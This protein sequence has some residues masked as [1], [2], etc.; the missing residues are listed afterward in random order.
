MN[1]WVVLLAVI[2]VSAAGCK[3]IEITPRNIV[4][5][6][7]AFK[8][9]QDLTKALAGAYAQLREGGYY[10]GRYQRVAEYLSDR[11]DGS[12]L[13]GYD[14]DIYNFKSS[15]DNGTGDT[16]SNP[17]ILI[18]RANTVLENLSLASSGVKNKYEGE[19][20]FLRA[21]GH[22]D[23]VKFFAQPYGFTADNNH[24]GVV[25][26][27]S[28]AFEGNRS[29]N[30]VAEVYK[31]II[32]DLRNA[33]SLLPASNGN[34]YANQNAARALLA[35]VYFQ[36]NRFDSSY[37]FSNQVISSGPAT[38]DNSPAFVTRRFDSTIA[39]AIK[40]P[41]AIFTLGNEANAFLPWDGL[42]NNAVDS[43][44]LGLR[45]TAGTYAAGTL[46]NDLRK[47]WYSNNA[48]TYGIK[49]Y[50]NAKFVQPLLHV[51]EMKLIRAESAAELNQNLSVAIGDINDITNRAYSGTVAPLPGSASAA[52]IKSLVR[53]Q[54]KLE[55]I[56]EGD[57]RLQQIKRIGAK[58]ESSNIGS[59]SWNC[60]GL[61]LQ[62]P[63]SEVNINTN[64]I[65]NPQGNCS[66]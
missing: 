39:G 60:Y 34:F 28:S 30:T 58:G 19:A 61:I 14:A 12:I 21:L 62:F 50:K 32:N 45:I 4:P 64:F 54:R 26:K 38:F 51:T 43:L 52:L 13:T 57:D 47:A 22:F 17:Y 42:R 53:D 49:K 9:E 11:I 35:R 7:D 48:G 55:M 3:K 16:Y 65:P 29:R 41:E 8:T 27:T 24:P 2:A 33:E 36:M 10:G 59:A 63:A 66:R 40:N 37:Y 31:A 44:N 20:R 23:A 6:A 25:I 56:F 5:P 18:Q 1:K 46:S 15:A